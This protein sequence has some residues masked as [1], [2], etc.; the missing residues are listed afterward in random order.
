[1]NDISGGGV[2]RNVVARGGLD[3]TEVEFFVAREDATAQ[4]T[5]GVLLR[6]PWRYP[7]PEGWVT[8]ERGQVRAV[9]KIVE[10]YPNLYPGNP[11]GP[12]EPI[13]PEIRLLIS[14]EK[15]G[16]DDLGEVL[17]RDESAPSTLDYSS[18]EEPGW[19]PIPR[20][21][22][23]GAALD[24]VEAYRTRIGWPSYVPPPAGRELQVVQADGK[25]LVMESATNWAGQIMKRYEANGSTDPTFDGE[26]VD[27]T[28]DPSM[29][30]AP[31]LVIGELPDGRALAVVGI[32]RQSRLIAFDR[33]SGSPADAAALG[34]LLAVLHRDMPHS[35]LRSVLIRADGLL[36]IEQFPTPG[37]I[38]FPSVNGERLRSMRSRV[39]WKHA[40]RSVVAVR[41]MR[42]CRVVREG[43]GKIDVEIRRL[44]NLENPASV[45]VKTVAGSATE[46]VDFEPWR[47]RVLFQ[48]GRASQKISIQI[49]SNAVPEGVEFFD[50]VLTQAAN[51]T[52]AT[53]RHRIEILESIE[54]Q[55]IPP[56][57]LRLHHPGILNFILTRIGADTHSPFGRWSPGSMLVSRTDPVD[58]HLDEP[59][60][61]LPSEGV[62]DGARE[63][64]V[65][66]FRGLAREEDEE[67]L[68]NM[69]TAEN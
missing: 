35:L 33:T 28:G 64:S 38:Q 2:L 9:G 21:R 40:P 25:W 42:R 57:T 44:G 6:D 61:G 36:E 4:E 58:F 43:A 10:L 22:H 15:D 34:T 32:Q 41:Q 47:G 18:L 7:L 63:L 69:I 55:W 23:E 59:C 26:P 19:V 53:P 27:V 14:L 60:C 37:V 12:L 50:L 16:F 49:H 24:D 13:L 3:S 68:P 62:A 31:L 8:F 1:M 66:F 67:D 46:G 54:L 17:L 30:T 51:M 20:D 29:V 52:I 48:S 39:Y 56:R 5:R 65:L 45:E 11:L